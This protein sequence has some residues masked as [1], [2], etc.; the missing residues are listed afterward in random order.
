MKKGFSRNNFIKKV[1]QND[2]HSYDFIGN[3]V[4]GLASSMLKISLWKW[5]LIL[6]NIEFSKTSYFLLRKSIPLQFSHRFIKILN[7]N[8][9]CFDSFT[10]KNVWQQ[11]ILSRRI[12]DFV[13]HCP[14]SDSYF[15]PWKVD[16]FPLKSLTVTIS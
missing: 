12:K 9:S 2:W 3:F 15:N 14:T 6:F 5:T 16:L 4:S 7:L 10:R 1:R 8:R 13:G 11:F